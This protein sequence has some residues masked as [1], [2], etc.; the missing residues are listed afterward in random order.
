MN[1]DDPA[2]RPYAPAKPQ[3]F[4][5][6]RKQRVAQGA[7]VRENEIVFRQ[8]GKDEVVLALRDIPLAG[9]HNIE[10]VLA[11]VAAARL[12][13]A[14]A[15]ETPRRARSFAGVGTLEFVAGW[16]GALPR[17]EKRPTGCNYEALVRSLAN[18]DCLGGKDKAAITP[19]CRSRCAKRR[20]LR[21]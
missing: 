13:G 20:F 19:H 16:R 12:T 18:P 8:D 14:R 4:W 3:V 10:N 9:A 6:S 15:A 11:A 21:C 2:T 1:A 17:F 5:F 7:F